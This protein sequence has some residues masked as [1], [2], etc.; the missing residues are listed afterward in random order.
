VENIIP[1]PYAIDIELSKITTKLSETINSSYGLSLGDKYCI[2]LGILMDKPIYTADKIWKQF[3]SQLSVK[4][5]LI[6]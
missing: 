3:E 6:R 2:A 1:H 5:N 4:I